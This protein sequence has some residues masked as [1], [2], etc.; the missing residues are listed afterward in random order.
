MRNTNTNSWVVWGAEASPFFLKVIAMCRFKQLPF[1]HLPLN[2]GFKENLR[3]QFRQQKLMAGKLP[4]T[5]PKM[6]EMDE[7]PEMPYIFGPNG[8]NLYDSTAIAYWLD[9]QAP[10]TEATSDLAPEGDRLL[11]FVISLIDEYADEYGLYLVHHFRWKVSAGDTMM[12]EN[13][14]Y[15]F[16][17]GIGL[18]RKPMKVFLGIRQTVRM[19]YLF[20]VAPK[21]FR[22]AQ[23]SKTFVQPPSR[24]GFPP[25]HELL[26]KSY[27]NLLAAIEPVLK[28]QPY[29]LGNR[30]TLAD[31][32]IYGQ[33][34]MNMADPSAAK[35]IKQQAPE[36]YKWLARIEKGDFSAS[37]PDG[38]LTLESSL[39][40]L[41]TEICRVF[42]PLMQQN[43]KASQDC[44]KRGETLF[45]EKA[46]WKNRSLYDG[47]L[48]GTP[49]RTVVKSFQVKTW[50]ELRKQW[51][52]LNSAERERM[53]QLLPEH[54]GL[55]RDD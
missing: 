54:H 33:L 2:G 35:M 36:T 7:F 53:E 44:R 15:E 43:Y 22:L 31:A 17:N 48:D 6:T 30:F 28:C 47:Q 25:T 10:V 23:K 49:F 52:A 20:S 14:A 39:T 32:S 34:E 40:P 9:R 11:K 16:R 18:L 37:K 3:Y 4:L 26:E 46:F 24:K 1:R 19:P 5:W 41:L 13:T 27:D 55:D 42:V 8:E 45:N 38:K 50:L 21:G 51:D 12:T 29:L